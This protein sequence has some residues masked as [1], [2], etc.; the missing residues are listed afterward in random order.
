MG[1]ESGWDGQVVE[2]LCGSRRPQW[3]G[4][5]GHDHV[6]ERFSLQTHDGS[7]DPTNGIRQFTVGTGGT[8]LTAL[9]SSAPNS[10]V[11][12]DDAHGVLKLDLSNGS[13]AWEFVSVAGSTASDSGSDACVDPSS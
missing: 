12:I 11:G 4:V 2:L 9:G 10:E 6:Y 13:Y 1:G 5:A 7:S 3:W 8:E